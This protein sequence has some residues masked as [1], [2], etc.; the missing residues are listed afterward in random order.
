M[1]YEVITIIGDDELIN[2]SCVVRDMQKSEEK[3]V[4]FEE[5][6]Q[7]IKAGIR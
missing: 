3:T 5:L 7:M 4:S 2:G 6:N 1:L